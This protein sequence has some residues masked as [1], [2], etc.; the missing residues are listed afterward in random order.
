MRKRKPRVRKQRTRVRP[1][2]CDYIAYLP[3]GSVINR[4]SWVSTQDSMTDFTVKP[5]NLSRVTYKPFSG[6]L[7]SGPKFSELVTD[8][9]GFMIDPTVTMY[10]WT[11]YVSHLK[12][13]KLPTSNDANLL[14]A[15][16]ELDDTVGMLSTSLKTRPSYG[17]VKWGWMPLIS[18]INAA[19]DAAN[20]VK[21]SLLEGNLR[22]SG[23]N[24]THRITKTVKNIP[25]FGG[26]VNHEW[27]VK[28]KHIG[29]ISYENDICAFYDYLGF[30]PTPKLAWDL[31]PLSF[32]VDYIL[33]IGDMLRSLTPQ[34]G[35]VKNANFTGWQVITAT[36]KEISVKPPSAYNGMTFAANSGEATF[37]TRTH[38]SGAH[39]SQKTIPRAIDLVKKPSLEQLMDLSYL[40]EAFYMRAK[41]VFSPHVYKKRRR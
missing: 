1:L 37:V 6:V 15:L 10:I 33:P 40:S 29:R 9:V 28:V 8:Y 22:T 11:P 26:L 25:Y 35:W 19:N 16:A 5:G 36:V 18:D 23:Y 32:A 4:A 14:T 13:K 39:L 24:A 38:L 30:H 17:G 7:R 27:D 12:V 3:D 31:V 41:K 2:A 34:Q 21:N 20:N